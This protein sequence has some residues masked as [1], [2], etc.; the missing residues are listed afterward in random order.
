[1][2]DILNTEQIVF[3]IISFSGSARS[4]VFEALKEV[5]KG[6]MAQAAALLSA[7]DHELKEAHAVQT[8]IIQQEAAGIEMN[9]NLLMVHAQDHLMT[10]MLARDLA[11]EIVYLN[12]EINQIKHD[13]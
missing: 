1:M 6:N 9:V 11:D 12:K 7:A 10:S 2:M 5:K 3:S 13:R 4:H 8:D